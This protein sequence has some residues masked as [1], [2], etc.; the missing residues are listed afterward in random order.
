MAQEQG[1]LDGGSSG[2][3]RMYERL[4][5]NKRGRGGRGAG[6]PMCPRLARALVFL[7]SS[8]IQV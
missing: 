5:K 3:E 8:N 4:D 6:Y 1:Y 2:I 7:A